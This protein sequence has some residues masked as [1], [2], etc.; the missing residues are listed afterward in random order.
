VY[1]P[2][3]PDVISVQLG[4]NPVLHISPA[5][6]MEIVVQSTRAVLEAARDGHKVPP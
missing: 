1:D 2:A 3:F 4:I 5:E 6:A